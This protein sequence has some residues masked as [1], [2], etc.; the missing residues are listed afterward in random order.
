MKKVIL[1]ITILITSTTLFANKQEFRYR[2]YD[3]VRDFYKSIA[4]DAYE[5]GMKYNIP[6]AAVLAIAGVESGYGRGYVARITGN[7]LSLGAN[8]GDAELPA[9]YLP[10]IKKT[11]EIIYLPQ[12][13]AKYS[14]DELLYKK[15]AKSLKKDYRP[16]AIAGQQ[17]EL[18]Y[19]HKNPQMFAKAK[20]KNLEDFTSKWISEKS[21]IPVFRDSKAWLEK[22]VKLN[23]KKTLLSKKTNLEFI[24]GIGGKPM[25][26]NYRETWPKKVKAVMKNAGLVEL[27]QEIDKGKSFKEAW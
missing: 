17:K 11:S 4:K 2:K 14:K 26:F 1:I 19:F 5:L 24:D 12:N 7:I 15:R 25:S 18:D 9:L 20:R 21:N 22:Q 10:S 6:P 13:I 3:H 23:G 27:I 8:K 16:K